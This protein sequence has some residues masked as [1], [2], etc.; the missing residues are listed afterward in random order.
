MFIFLPLSLSLLLFSSLASAWHLKWAKFEECEFLIFLFGKLA[1]LRWIWNEAYKSFFEKVI[2]LL[3][4]C[5]N[6]SRISK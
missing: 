5:T 3:I 4:V 1:E 2:Y 6:F